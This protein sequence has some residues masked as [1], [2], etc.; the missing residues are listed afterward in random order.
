M[1]ARSL[2]IRGAS[3]DYFLTIK[4]SSEELIR[5]RGRL[6][7]ERHLEAPGGRLLFFFFVVLGFLLHSINYN[8]E[9]PV[10]ATH[11]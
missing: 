8:K 9:T 5:V 10:A 4:V 3:W 7:P 6:A 2:Y 1:R 11:P